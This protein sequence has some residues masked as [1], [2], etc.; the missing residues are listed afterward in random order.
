MYSLT[1]EESE[2]SGDMAAVYP[3]NETPDRETVATT[4]GNTADEREVEVDDTRV[5]VT[6][7]WS[8]EP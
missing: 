3:E 4:V 5:S 2:L 8:V 6:G 1:L 7:T